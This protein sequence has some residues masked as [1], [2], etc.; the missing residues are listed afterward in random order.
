MAILA[1][2]ACVVPA[3]SEGAI[4]NTVTSGTASLPN[5]ATPTQVTLS[6]IDI[7]RAFVVCSTRTANSSGDAGLF[8]C[9]LNTTGGTP[10]LTI[11]P[12]VAPGNTTTRVQYYVAEFDAGVSVQRGIATFSGTSL[13]PTATPTLTAVDCT[14]SFVLTSVRSTDSSAARDEMTR[15]GPCARSSARAP[16]RARAALRPASSSRATTGRAR[17]RSLWPGRS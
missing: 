5:S 16:R 1:A 9:D 14:K 4:V 13:T 6:G 12:S 15:Y 17:R 3:V 2:L 11:T 8:T 7:T 10:R